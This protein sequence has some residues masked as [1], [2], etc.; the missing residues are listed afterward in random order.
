MKDHWKC[1]NRAASDT[2]AGYEWNLF[3]SIDALNV[4]DTYDQVSMVTSTKEPNLKTL[5]DN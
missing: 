5:E 4:D 1:W 2:G 3:T